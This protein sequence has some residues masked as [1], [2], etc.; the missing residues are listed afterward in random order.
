MHTY[1]TDDIATLI[2]KKLDDNHGYVGV[3]DDMLAS[4]IDTAQRE[5]VVATRCLFDN[6]SQT[7]AV[8][9]NTPDYALDDNILHLRNGFL[10]TSAATV[11]PTTVGEIETAYIG[12]DYGQIQ[13]NW[14][15]ATGTPRWMITD[16]HDEKIIL[17]PNPVVTETLTISAHLYPD[18]VNTLDDA[19]QIPNKWRKD[20]IFGVLAELY[21]IQDSELYDPRAADRNEGVWRRKLYQRSAEIELTKRGPGV[22]RKARNGYW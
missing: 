22:V 13:C 1:T 11:T 21:M 6:E 16:L 4:A 2:R 14:R 9:A 12:T 8:T 20:L 5:F 10:E 19:M 17:V 15:T 7:I 18:V 3:D